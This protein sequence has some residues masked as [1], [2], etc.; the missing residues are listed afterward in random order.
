[1]SDF[2]GVLEFGALMPC[3]GMGD[4]GGL[5]RIKLKRAPSRAIE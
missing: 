3:M 4:D 2:S 1:M 5:A